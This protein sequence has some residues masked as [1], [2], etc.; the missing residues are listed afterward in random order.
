MYGIYE[1]GKLTKMAKAL[2][3]EERKIKRLEE[4]NKNLREQ[5]KVNYAEVYKQL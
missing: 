4:E 2:Y 1:P 3:K 5:I